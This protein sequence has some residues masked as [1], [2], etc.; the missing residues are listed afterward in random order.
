MR[1]NGIKGVTSFKGL[2]KNTF[3]T[4]KHFCPWNWGFATGKKYTELYKIYE[5]W[6]EWFGQ[7]ARG[8]GKTNDVITKKKKKQ[9]P[10]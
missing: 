5:W 2:Q 8:V 4:F 6:D 10:Y 7:F 3:Y 1:N 9:C